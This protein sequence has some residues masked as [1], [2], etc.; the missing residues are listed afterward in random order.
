MA[1]TQNREGQLNLQFNL[2]QSTWPGVSVGAYNPRTV[3]PQLVS[4][5]S[6]RRH[7]M[8]QDQGMWDGF[9]GKALTANLAM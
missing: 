2:E 8:K 7:L 9:E 3:N 5:G 1:A 4:Q 6:T